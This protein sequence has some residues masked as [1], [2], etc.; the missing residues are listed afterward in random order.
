ML[1]TK[2]GRD[3]LAVKEQINFENKEQQRI[4][5]IREEEK[6]N[7]LKDLSTWH[8]AVEHDQSTKSIL[9]SKKIAYNKLCILVIIYFINYSY[10]DVFYPTLWSLN[11]QI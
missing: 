6:K 4:Q 10:L 2:T 1:V 9:H 3:R 5:S 7:V 8:S 11:K